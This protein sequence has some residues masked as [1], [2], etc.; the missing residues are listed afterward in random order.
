M[1]TRKNRAQ[2]SDPYQRI[3]DPGE[4]RHI[5]VEEH[6][7][8]ED[9]L[10]RSR[11]LTE[12]RGFDLRCMRNK[13]EDD[14]SC[15]EDDVPADERDRQPC[16]NNTGDREEYIGCDEQE[17]ICEGIEEG[18]QDCLLICQACNQPVEG[19]GDCG[20]EEEIKR[21]VIPAVDDRHSEEWY[22]QYP[23]YGECIRDIQGIHQDVSTLFPNPKGC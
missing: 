7:P 5:D 4:V 14:P 12:E 16:G 10:H 9:E 21:V 23:H 8:Y 17:L 20:C 19:I 22:D 13:I 2:R 1:Q 18:P 11:D 3:L 6:I 15:D